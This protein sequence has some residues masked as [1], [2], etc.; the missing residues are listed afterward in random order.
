MLKAIIFLVSIIVIYLIM[1]F[2]MKGWGYEPIRR[3]K[4]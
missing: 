3:N 4:K 1:I 2:W